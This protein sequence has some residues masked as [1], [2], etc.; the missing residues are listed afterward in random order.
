M[1]I[2][3]LNGSPKATRSNTYHLAQIFLEELSKK[4]EIT[5]QEFHANKDFPD[6]C[7][8]CFSCILHDEHKCPHREKINPIEQAIL[9]ADL[10][11]FLTPVYVMNMSGQMKTLLDHFGYWFVIHRPRKEFQ[12]KSAFIL[13]STA[14]D[15]TFFAINNIK[16][17]LKFW[18][19]PH[20]QSYGKALYAVN[21]KSIQ[22][23]NPKKYHKI[24]KAIQSKAKKIHKAYLKKE[25]QK[26]SLYFLLYRAIMR[27]VI[28]RYDPQHI[29]RIYWLENGWIKE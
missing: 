17:V 18:G 2:C 4:E 26:P 10:L 23:N 9:E 13:S 21:F 5:I 20:I 11:I 14:G 3:L 28:K 6:F 27:P 1:K 16:R 29:D 25:R 12:T 8:G 7:T 22:Q 15:G 24:T 19:I